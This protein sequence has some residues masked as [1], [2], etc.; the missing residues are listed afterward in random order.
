MNFAE[1]YE[2]NINI[3]AYRILWIIFFSGFAFFALFIVSGVISR[4]WLEYGINV[5][6]VFIVFGFST[7]CRRF[8]PNSNKI[9]YL[10]VTTLFLGFI[11]LFYMNE[12]SLAMSP[13]WLLIIIVSL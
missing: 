9:K 13:L 2:N 6:T 1:S 7:L 5:T 10:L 3:L 11:S 4:T 8:Y 12:V